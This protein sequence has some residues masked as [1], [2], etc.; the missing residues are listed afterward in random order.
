APRTPRPPFRPYGQVD[1]YWF[2]N[3]PEGAARGGL[4]AIPL[5]DRERSAFRRARRAASVISARDR[6]GAG[7]GRSIVQVIDA[8]DLRPAP[9]RARGAA[10]PS[11]RGGRGAAP[12]RLVDGGLAPEHRR[13]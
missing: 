6:G 5:Q 11:L 9:R 13:I 10:Y 7:L 12:K 2:T 8:A 4:P 3:R 1:G